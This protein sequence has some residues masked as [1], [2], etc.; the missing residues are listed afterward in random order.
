MFISVDE[1][2]LLGLIAGDG[3]VGDNGVVIA[4]G[5]AIDMPMAEEAERVL[6]ASGWPLTS[7]RIGMAKKDPPRVDCL[8]MW[9]YGLDLADHL[10]SMGPFGIHRWRILDV[11]LAA[12]D[13]HVAAWIAGFADAE[14]HVSHLPHKGARNVVID[15]VNL[16]GLRQIAKELARMGIK[17]RMTSHDREIENQS[18]GHK[19][20]V[21]NRAALER[22]AEVIPLRCPRKIATLREALASYKRRILTSDD[23]DA[24]LPEIKRRLAAQ[25]TYDVIGTAVGIKPGQVRN[26][27]RTR[28]LD[29]L[30]RGHGRAYQRGRSALDKAATLIQAGKSVA[31]TAREVGVSPQTVS[32]GL[33][34]RGIQVKG[35]RGWRS[36]RGA[37]LDTLVPEARRLVDAGK[38][39]VE[40]A[41]ALGHEL[42]PTRVAAFLHKHGIKRAW[43]CEYGKSPKPRHKK[44]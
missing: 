17:V 20:H 42:T 7:V 12:G 36:D 4:F 41:E 27:V 31:A 28:N 26:A 30:G 14:G 15:S 24:V 21:C 35:R 2:W 40:I 34:A 6:R 33:K 8:Q 22:F 11:V 29:G 39:N 23:V 44:A 18:V 19:L 5:D 37:E 43:R 9:A 3:H 1:A 25:E 16:V 32:E 38:S 10:R 13:A